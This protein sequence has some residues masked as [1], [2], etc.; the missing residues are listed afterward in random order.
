MLPVTKKEVVKSKIYAVLIL[1]G[2]HLATGFLFGLIHNAIYGSYNIFFD[3]NIAFFGAMVLMYALFN[4]AFF[5]TYFKTGYFFG[6]AN[7][8]GVIVTLVYGFIIEFTVAKYGG[9]Q[10]IFEGSIGV[11]GLVLLVGLVLSLLLTVYTYRQSLYHY[12]RID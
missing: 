6:K 9:V 3:V 1:E 2:L 10:E 5:P 8:Y 11:Q 12:E 7:I 4:L